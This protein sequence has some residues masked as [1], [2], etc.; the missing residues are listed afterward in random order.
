MN[1][2]SDGTTLRDHFLGWQCRI[3][4]L[5]IRKMDGRPTSGMQPQVVLAGAD[6]TT[7]PVN[8]LIVKS[9]PQESTAQFRHM[10]KKTQDPLE[11]RESAMHLLASTYYQQPQG[12]SE[13]LTALFSVDSEILAMLLKAGSCVLEF[14][15]FSQSYRLQCRVLEL[16][17]DDP[18]F[19]AT[20][21]HNSLF[22]PGMPGKV[23]VLSF[24]PDWERSS[25]H[26]T[27]S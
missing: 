20:Y 12:F 22:N 16:A 18:A 2:P 4:Q 15:Q 21:W 8:T 13:D 11:R 25:A 24:H 7:G 1:K 23:R 26:P 27:V 5:S 6:T 10:V 14:S 9:D 19:Q 17:E 3:R